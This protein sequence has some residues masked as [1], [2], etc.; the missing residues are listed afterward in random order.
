M[1]FF[2]TYKISVLVQKHFTGFFFFYPRNKLC[3][4]EN[5]LKN[6]HA[7]PN[8]SHAGVGRVVEL[9][10]IIYFMTALVFDT[11]QCLL[12]RVGFSSC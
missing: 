1:D 5:Y 6:K 9:K 7:V 12:N 10:K 4:K 3:L 2:L 11:Q 8:K